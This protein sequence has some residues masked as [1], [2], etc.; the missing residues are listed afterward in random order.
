MSARRF[1]LDS[2][3]LIYSVDFRDPL[4][5]SIAEQ[6]VRT[7]VLRDCMLGLQSIGEF[8]TASTRK[9]IA[10]PTNASREAISL[11]TI[12]PTF[13]ATAKAHAIAAREAVAGRF[14]YW[15]AVLLASA[16]EAGCETVLSEDM[17]DG[18][19]LGGIT[20]RNPF[21][22]KGLSAAAVAALAP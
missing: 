1:S 8:Y 3:V 4:K 16:E 14:S 13:Q 10:T 20:V 2:N 9:G 18:A 5:Q 15:D 19:K 6:I 7:A 21:G 17:H 11:L 22:P 12:F